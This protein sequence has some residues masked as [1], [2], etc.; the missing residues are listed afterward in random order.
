MTRQIRAFL[1]GALAVGLIAFVSGAGTYAAF[2][3]VTSN[4]GNGAGTGNSIDAG[5]VDLHDNDSGSAMFVLSGMRPTDP[6]VSSCITVNYT[7]SLDSQVGLYAA[8]TGS[9]APYLNLTVW[10]GESTSGFGNCGTFNS[11]SVLYNGT[12]GAFP[13]TWGAIMDTNT[14]TSGASHSYKFTLSLQNTTAAQGLSSSAT[15]TWEARNL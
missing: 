15:F 9:L 12:L 13:A 5:T 4:D 8:V 14:W 7:G 11:T 6:A 2:F 10:A 1:V 3:S